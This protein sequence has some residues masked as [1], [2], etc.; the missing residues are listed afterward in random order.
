MSCTKSSMKNPVRFLF[1]SCFAAA[2]LLAS[3]GQPA[4]AA[5]PAGPDELFAPENLVAWCVVPF[6]AKRRGPAERAEMLQKLGFHKLAYDWRAEHVPTF[7]EE[8]LQLKK[9]GIEFFAFWATHED[10][11][12]LF[13]KY[14]LH[15]QIWMTAPS[16]AGDTDQ[17]RT[18]AAAR[19]LLPL[20]ERTR[21]LRCALGLYNHGGWGGEPS[22][23]V[24]VC[25]WLRQHAEADHVGIVY[26]WHHGH[27]HISD[28]PESLAAMK[29]Y[30]L[31]LNLNG[32]NDG[33]NP[34]IV[35]L[36]KGQHERAM[37]QTI[38]NSGYRGPIGILDH[39]GSIDA[40]QSLR[41]NL[42]GLQQ[43]VE[44]LRK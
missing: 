44:Q 19:T 3:A 43:L 15:P 26:N 17:A 40:Q 23:L 32:M 4:H 7:E 39:R 30:L 2:L 24:A 20:V 22:N 42:D 18:E 31:C 12:R 10:A 11:F 14:D 25:Q 37:M 28:W 16:P 34:Q 33:A 9:H 6:D 38:L 21:Q 13:E 35:P 8:I 41:E 29:P 5:D 1:V 27:A 36:G